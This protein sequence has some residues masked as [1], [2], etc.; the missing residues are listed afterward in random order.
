MV[1]GTDAL[2]G[3]LL[4]VRH[5]APV[6]A[7]LGRH[8]LLEDVLQRCHR[9]AGT[10]ARRS[11][12]VDLHALVQVLPHDELGAAA[13]IRAGQGAERHHI[14]RRIL[15]VKLAQIVHI[16][17]ELAVGLH[18]HLP[19]QPKLVVVVHQGAAHEGLQ[20][21]IH[22]AQ[23]DLLR[24][25][26]R[27]VDVHPNLRHAEQRGG[28]HAGQFRTL[29]GLGHECLGVLG[30]EVGAAAGPVFQNEGEPA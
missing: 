13:R 12:A 27:F 21:L 17:S 6:V 5:A 25:D 24:Q 23:I 30:Q 15:H 9:L 11:R 14:A 3:F 10:V 16:G 28:H 29:A 2:R 4:L 20:R 18:P 26:L 8:G 7:H 1:V 19:L 22:I